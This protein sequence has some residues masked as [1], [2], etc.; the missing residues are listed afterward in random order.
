MN[1]NN[2]SNVSVG[3]PVPAG[4]VFASPKGTALPTDAETP[5]PDVWKNLGYASD[6]GLTNSIS[7]STSEVVAWGG[8]PVLNTQTEYTETFKI[9]LIECMS[10]DVLKEVFGEDNVTEDQG[11]LGVSHN[12]KELPYHPWAFDMIMTGGR[13][14]RMVIPDGKVSEI[15]DMVYVDGDPVGYELTISCRSDAKSNTAYEYIA[16]PAA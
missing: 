2:A 7:R 14:K 13:L 15:G 3:K 16:A 5:L 6:A 11:V 10:F 8:Q 12:A 9:V 4:A 1:P